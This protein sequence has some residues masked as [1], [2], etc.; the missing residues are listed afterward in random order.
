MQSYGTGSCAMALSMCRQKTGSLKLDQ[1]I[2]REQVKCPMH[3]LG[4]HSHA[5]C[6]TSAEKR[7]LCMQPLQMSMLTL[8]SY[9]NCNISRLLPHVCAEDMG[10]DI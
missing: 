3:V 10:G 5:S 8:C 6:S 7:I 4:Y 1:S 2:G 9:K